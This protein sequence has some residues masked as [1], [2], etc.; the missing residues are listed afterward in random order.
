MLVT[1]GGTREPID[2]VRFISNRSSGKQGHALAEAAARRGAIVTLV[3]AAPLTAAGVEEIVRVD[4]ASEMEE[5]VLART[6]ASDV[7]IMAA[8]VADFRP[9]PRPIRSSARAMV[10]LTWCS[11][12][13]STSS[14]RWVD[15]AGRTRSSSASP[16]RPKKLS[17]A[18][19]RSSPP[20]VST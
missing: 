18:H 8:A 10:C 17:S 9:K 6:A 19:H 14:P 13:Q 4:T 20:K 1:A 3:T 15:D 11:S 16:P 5:A 12:R 2:P 7:V